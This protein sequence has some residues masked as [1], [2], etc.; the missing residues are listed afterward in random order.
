MNP[1][2]NKLT[3][4][5]TSEGILYALFLLVL[6]LSKNGPALFAIDNIDQAINPRLIK[7][8]IRLLCDWIVTLT[9]EKQLLC[10]AHNPSVLDGC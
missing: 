3:A 10:T 6:C 9:P 5:D 8:L 2:Y 7:E 4:A 1:K